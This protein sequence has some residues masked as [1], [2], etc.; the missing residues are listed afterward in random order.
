MKL[1]KPAKEAAG[2]SEYPATDEISVKFTV[3]RVYSLQGINFEKGCELRKS[4]SFG[5][6]EQCNIVV[7]DSVNKAANEICGEDFVD[8]EEEWKTRN[9]SRPPYL[10]ICF[11]ESKEHILKGGYRKDEGKYILTYDE[12]EH[13][14]QQ[15]KEWELKELPSII[16]SL[17][18][19][20]SQENLPVKLELI[21]R[22]VYGKTKDNKTLLDIKMTMSA[23]AFTSH[24]KSI[25][26][27]DICLA[28]SLK[29]CSVLD[30]KVSRFIFMALNETDYLKQ[31]LYYFIFIELFT[32]C[33]FKKI[34]SVNSAEHAS[35]IPA[36]IKIMGTALSNKSISQ[37]KTLSL[38]FL[39]CSLIL[40]GEINDSDIKLFRGFKKIRNDTA[41]GNEDSTE[42]P[43]PVAAIRA[44][45]FK[46]VSNIST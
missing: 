12:F 6:G 44:L 45:A 4:N 35:N 15:I 19:C 27:I 20:F 13:G 5:F 17:T 37:A 41:H 3:L 43:F 14:K 32:Q 23:N 2:Y 7:A 10:L 33:E 21:T 25:A 26:D 11:E 29:L 8:N 38:K 9:N 22:N 42:S 46:L 31:F 34:D 24:H 40:W 39:W 36:R 1:N 28:K 18:L 30:W 16:S